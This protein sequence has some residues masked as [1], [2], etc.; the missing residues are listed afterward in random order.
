MF[1]DRLHCKIAS[2]Q[3]AIRHSQ[4]TSNDLEISDRQIAIA[5][6]AKKECQIA[7]SI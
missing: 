1:S 6:L 3:L 2:K 7:N 5:Y 4:I